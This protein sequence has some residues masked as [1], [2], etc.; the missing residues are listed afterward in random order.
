M[1]MHAWHSAIKGRGLASA[2]AIVALGVALALG[3][4]GHNNQ[5]TGN[6]GNGGATTQQTSTDTNTTTTSTTPATP[7]G[8]QST[9]DS[10]E[11]VYTN[12]DNDMQILSLDQSGLDQEVQP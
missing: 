6:G 9:I 2:A 10:L 3:G 8:L 12:L 7:D 11:M 5:W 1:Q 4:C